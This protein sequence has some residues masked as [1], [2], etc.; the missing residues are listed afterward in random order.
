MVLTND[1]MPPMTRWPVPH[2]YHHKESWWRRHMYGQANI[3]TKP[4]AQLSVFDQVMWLLCTTS[5]I[6]KQSAKLFDVVE[7][8]IDQIKYTQE[9]RGKLS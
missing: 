9:T 6:S 4:V 3:I 2:Y 8:S 1:M 7:A 5:S